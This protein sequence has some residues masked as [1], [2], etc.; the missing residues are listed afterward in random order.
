MQAAR[1]DRS[2]DGGQAPG[3]T[4]GGARPKAL[5]RVLAFWPLLMAGVLAILV[6][7]VYQGWVLTHPPRAP[8]T[9]NPGTDAS[10][11]YRD[12]PCH[13]QILCGRTLFVPG[14]H[15]ALAGWV[16]PLNPG[17]TYPGS[18]GNWAQNTVI[19]VADHGQSRT[20]GPFPLW[21]VASVLSEMGYNVVLYDAEGTG[22]SGGAAIAFGT[23]EV[24][25]LLTVVSWLQRQGPAQGHIAVWGLGTGADT[26]ILAAARN[27]AIS[28]VIADSPYARPDAFLRRAIPRWTG[29]PAFPFARTIL[30]AMQQETRV[31]YGAYDP[32]TAVRRLGEG[33]AAPGRPLLLVS[34]GADTLTPPADASALYAASHDNNALS[35]TVVGAGHLQAMADSGQ[36][37]VP[38]LS[39]YMCDALD[40]L[41]AMQTGSSPAQEQLSAPCGGAARILS[42]PDLP[43]LPSSVGGRGATGA[44]G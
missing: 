31:R 19:F 39:V 18:S 26:A 5:L 12:L 37:A 2:E 38:G 40:T 17:S 13:H 7:S 22:L 30:W 6:V 11:E 10:L 44:V 32:L 14:V 21:G 3:A 41:A 16:I 35:L 20:S 42:A 9:G 29:L 43:P 8:V 24:R 27:P 28:A 33:P 15:L 25:D 1:D 34:G 4:G 23:L 36:G